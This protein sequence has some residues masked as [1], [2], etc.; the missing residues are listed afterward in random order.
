MKNIDFIDKYGTFRIKNPENYSGLYLPLAGEKGLKSSITPTLGG[1]SK[2]SQN[3][4]LLEPVSI[5]NLHNNKGTR[6]FWCRIV[7]KG[8]WSVCGSS[9][10]QEADRFTGNQ[11]ESELEAGLMWQKLH[12]AS[13]IYGLE[14]DT[15]SFVT[16]DGSMEV[17]LVEITNKTDEAMEI[18][19][20]GAIPIYGR[21]ADNIRDHR[22]VTSLLH[23]IETT[24]YGIEVTPVLSFDE[25]GHRKNDIS[26]FV[27][28]SSG[29]GESPES[30]YPT[31]EQFIGEGGSFLIPE[32]VRTEKA[33]AKAGEKFQGKEAVGAIKFANRII[34]PLETVSYIMLAG[35]TEKENDV[36]AI[37]GRYRSVLEVK[38]ELNTVKKH[39]I[40]KV[41]I[42][43]ETGNAEEDN[44]LKWICFQPILRRIYGCSFLPHHDYGKGGRGWRDLW[45]DCLALLLMEPSDV[46]RMIVNNYGGVR[47]DGTNATIIGNEPGEFIADRNNITR[48]WMDHAFWP[49]VTTKLYIDQTGDTDVLF[50]HT[51]YFKDY[52]SMRGTSHDEAWNTTYGNKQRT[53]GGQIYFGTVLEHILIQNLCAFYD[54]GEHNEMKLHG[55]DW[56]DALDM[57]WDKGESV[58]FTCAYAGNLLDIAK[59]LRNVEKISG[60]N[61]IEVLDELKL[62]LADDEI[63]YNC[64]DKKQDLLMSYAK[65][66]ENCTS[67][68]TAL[69]P[70]AAICENLEHKAEWMMKNIRENEWIS[71]GTDGGWFNGYYDNNGRPVERCE[72][73]DVRM[74]LTGQVFAIMS[75][76]AKKEQ[77]KAIC[78][79]ADKYLFDQKAG[80]YRLNTDFKEEKFDLGRMFGFAYGEKENGPVHK[81]DHAAGDQLSAGDLH[82]ARGRDEHLVERAE[83]PFPRHGQAG[84][85]HPHQEIDRADQI[86]QDE[87]AEIEVRVEPVQSLDLN[88][89]RLGLH[90]SGRRRCQPLYDLLDILRQ[91]LGCIGSP[92][93]QQQLHLGGHAPLHLGGKI[94]LEVHH[95]QHVLTVDGFF[96]LLE[97]VLER[98]VPE[99][100]RTAQPADDLLAPVP[101]V[102]VDHHHVHV[103]HFHRGRPRKDENLDDRRDQHHEPA[104]PRA[105]EHQQLFP[106][107]RKDTAKR[108]HHK[109]DLR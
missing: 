38:E 87:P 103:L 57:A 41:N 3:T 80:G 73:G 77:I 58:A 70:I 89:G 85:D 11:D 45:Q 95:H 35:L 53:A 67:G 93:V 74:M 48:V 34:K 21:S 98:D 36:N 65:A 90:E 25:R 60:I 37:T 109:I 81:A 63:L 104:L 40:D 68:G 107:N 2:T 30:F 105:H 106:R 23:R 44:Y 82:R 1:D 79:S 62:L 99:G 51:T 15:T 24:Q 8:F 46:R 13:K 39:W 20:I 27:Y 42:D 49:F 19:P 16:L 61:R 66:C 83:L 59:C 78:N 29:N 64:H 108:S 86:R 9:A 84:N 33:G 56:N 101:R 4:F 6:N 69:I 100:R 76:T 14:A 52:Q 12:R 94:V 28:G 102:F 71:D 75:G 55:A 96:G 22:H 31:V 91:N 92:P 17:M 50:E 72:S 97:I 26:Y 18:V 5:E 7:G 54:V 10:Q 88:A 32:A 43:F 47:I